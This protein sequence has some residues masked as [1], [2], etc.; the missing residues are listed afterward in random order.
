MLEKFFPGFATKL[1]QKKMEY[2]I[3]KAK[4]EYFDK[5][6]EILNYG[7]S[8]ASTSK[9][10]FRNSYDY[11]NSVDEDIGDNKEILTARSLQ[12]FMGNTVSR[13]AINKI[14][15]NVVGRGIK[16]KPKIKNKIL[17]LEES[18]VEKIQDDIQTIWELWAESTECDIC[19]MDNLYKLQNLAII[20]HLIYGECFVLLPFS[21]NSGEIFETKIKF[22]DGAKCESQITTEFIKHGV[23]FDKDGVPIAYHFNIGNGVF[24]RIPTF[25]TKLKGKRNLIHIMDKERIG[26]RRGVPLL[27]PVIETLSQITRYTNAELTNAVISALFTAFIISDKDTIQNSKIGGVTLTEPTPTNPNTEISLGSGNIAEL[28][29]GKKIEFANPERPNQNFGRFT[30]TLCKQIGAALE[31]PVEVLL[32][33]FNSSFS[34]SKAAL[35]EVWKMYLTRREWLISSFCQPVYETFIDE[36][37]DRGLLNLKGYKEDPLIRRAY[38]GVEWYGQT[39][40]QIDP[41]KETKAAIARIQSGLSTLSRETSELN[42]S[43]WETN[44]EQRKI[45]EKKLKEVNDIRREGRKNDKSIL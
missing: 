6:L 25:S 29:P 27:A 19:R 2:K 34:A 38:L 11:I 9:I 26:Q 30:E 8:G 5:T 41:V 36:C 23:E 44:L 45:E 17:K 32:T 7:Q 18:E 42:G 14:R 37:V 31:I 24:K 3:T 16:A 22:I 43:N 21:R 33:S 28:P 13:A 20:T 39:Q 1:E 35:L 4:S 10:A 15:T 12:L 40:G